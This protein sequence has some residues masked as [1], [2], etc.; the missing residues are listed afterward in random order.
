MIQ[1][2]F[3]AGRLYSKCHVISSSRKT[4][5]RRAYFHSS[6]HKEG[7]T[8]CSCVWKRG[9][10]YAELSIYFQ[11]SVVLQASIVH[12]Q[13]KIDSWFRIFDSTPHTASEQGLSVGV[14]VYYVYVACGR[15][16][17]HK[18]LHQLHVIRV[19][20]LDLIS[21]ELLF[22]TLFPRLYSALWSLRSVS[23]HVRHSHAFF[24]YFFSSQLF[25]GPVFPRSID[26][27]SHQWHCITIL[28][29]LSCNSPFYWP[30]CCV[31]FAVRLWSTSCPSED[32]EKAVPMSVLRSLTHTSFT[33][34]I[35]SR[36]KWE[37]L[38][39]I[40]FLPSVKRGLDDA[41]SQKAG[42]I[43]FYRCFLNLVISCVMCLGRYCV[44]LWWNEVWTRKKTD[45]LTAVVSSCTVFAEFLKQEPYVEHVTRSAVFLHD[46]RLRDIFPHSIYFC[47]C[48]CMT[49]LSLPRSLL[50]LALLLLP[51]AP[52]LFS[53]S[54]TS[55]KTDD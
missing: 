1:Q 45:R 52:Y 24:W 47:C 21:G 40:P 55:G 10:D 46:S 15:I 9:K 20:S 25:P 5:S 44:S 14:C 4:F 7:K 54:L 30:Y 16:P 11:W 43:D 27:C 6:E 19:L 32:G 2:S 33:L 50:P 36:D 39:R 29:Y 53:F 13:Q 3:P 22:G 42:S 28:S 31:I 41:A 23:S 38:F 34:A 49:L 18:M 26:G 17:S 37:M 12:L 48:C 35:F 8:Q 51:F